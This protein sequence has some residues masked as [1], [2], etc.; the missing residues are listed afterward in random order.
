MSL[1]KKFDDRLTHCARKSAVKGTKKHCS[2]CARTRGRN[3][4]PLGRTG[5]PGHADFKEGD[6]ESPS[7]QNEFQRPVRGDSEEKLDVT[8]A[9]QHPTVFQATLSLC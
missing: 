1:V 5:M 3:G 7:N 8:M 6:K 2:H 4:G 9:Q